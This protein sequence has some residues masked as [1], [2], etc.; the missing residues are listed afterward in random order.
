MVAAMVIFAAL[1]VLTVA[2]RVRRYWRM[3]DDPKFAIRQARREAERL[4]R[5]PFSDRNEDDA[6]G[7]S[8]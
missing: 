1:L 6:W 2:W 4:N 8:W 7:S 3:Y 5:R